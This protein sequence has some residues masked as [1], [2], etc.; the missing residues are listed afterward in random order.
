[1]LVDTQAVLNPTDKIF[2][3]DQKVLFSLRPS[4]C[5]CSDTKPID[6][7]SLATV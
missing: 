4:T 1:M 5:Y 3:V 2:M 7:I 6:R